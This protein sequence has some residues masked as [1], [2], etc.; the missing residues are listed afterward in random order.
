MQKQDKYSEIQDIVLKNQD[1]LKVL[2]E[3]LVLVLGEEIGTQIKFIVKN[4]KQNAQDENIVFLKIINKSSLRFLVIRKQE[5]IGNLFLEKFRE[6][7]II[8]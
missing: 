4:I 5:E 7:L 2:R 1:R 8:K 6:N 3:V